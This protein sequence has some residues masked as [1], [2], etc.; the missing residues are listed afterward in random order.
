MPNAADLLLTNAIV[1]TMERRQ[2]LAEAVAVAGERIIAV[3]SARYLGRFKGRKTR[4]IDCQRMTLIPGLVDAHC[5]LLAMAR[6]LTQVDCGSHRVRSIIE[7]QQIIKAK[8]HQ[9]PGGQWVRGCGYDHLALKEGRHPTRW[10]LDSATANHPV[11]L[12]H[13]SGHATVLNSTGLNLAGIHRDTQDPIDGVIQR[14]STSGE[15]TGLLLEMSG[16]LRR[17]LGDDRG[18]AE[19]KPRVSTLN[20]RLL[21]NGITSVQDA[22]P[23]NDLARWSTFQDLVS[24]KQMDCRVSMMAGMHHLEEFQHSGTTWGVGNLCLR[25]GHAKIMLTMT[26]GA[27]YPGLDQLKELVSLSH[28]AG[29]PV[30]IHA[31][32]SEAVAAAAQAIEAAETRPWNTTTPPD[33][34]EHCS[35]CPPQLLQQVQRSGATVVT[36]PGFIYWNGDGYLERVDPELPPHLYPIG[37]LAR[38]RIPVAFGSDAPVIDPNPWVGIHAAVA[39]LTRQG[40]QLPDDSAPSGDQKVSVLEAL[41]MYTLAGAHAEGTG[42]LKGSIRCGKL[43]DLVLL[44]ADP[45]RIGATG[46][47]DIE[48]VLTLVGGQILWDRGL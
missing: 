38:A 19:F 30:A 43:A 22:G 37:E 28:Q 9:T 10:D 15:P 16:F 12:D 39:R 24:S 44:D 13:R 14:D 45:T 23:D 17:R 7:L 18:Q 34:I 29:F 5:H 3:G 35:E 40:Q 4:V 32:E 48:A 6:G 11:R 47:K 41:K 8:A 36:Q 26:T 42:S 21:Q 31:V 1:L 33:R 46:L 25:L 20:Q 2:P 27:L